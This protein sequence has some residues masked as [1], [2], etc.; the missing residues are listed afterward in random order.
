MTAKDA[1]TERAAA[2]A[3]KL[4]A[5]VA[6]AILAMGE[7]GIP[8]GHLYAR[9]MGTITL[10]DYNTILGVLKKAGMVSESYHLLRWTGT[11][12]QADRMKRLAA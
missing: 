6:E 3:V 2:A 5:I 4:A 7:Q 9:L 8:S 10:D 1:A 12:A 11:P